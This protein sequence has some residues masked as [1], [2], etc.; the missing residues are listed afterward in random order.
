MFTKI[1]KSN[2]FFAILLLLAS[3]W[4]GR[5]LFGSGFYT[6]SDETHLANLHQMVQ[7]INSGQIPPRW[8]PNFSFNFG[9]P[10]FTFYYL[11]PYYIGSFFNIVFGLSLIWSLK[12]TFLITIIG[13]AL[14]MYFLALK[15]F[16][17]P[18]AFSISLIYLFTPYRAVDLY[19]RGAVGEM[20]G[21]V[22]MPLVLLTTINLLKKPNQTNLF[23][24]SLS[25][26]G[27][28]I[29][30]N[31][32]VL[33]FTP[34]IFLFSLVYLRFYLPKLPKIKSFLVLILSMAISLL[35]SAYY[36]IPAI[37]E[38]QYM[39]SGTPFNPIDHFPFI[40]QLIIPYWGYGAS[41]WGPTDELSFQIG[42]ANLMGIAIML[43]VVFL[44]KFKFKY[45]VLS[46]TLL[47]ILFS[48]LFLMN[49]RSLPIWDLIPIAS[50]IQF[51]WRLLIIT[52]FISPLIIGLISLASNH[53][54]FKII[55]YVLAFV[56]ILQTYPYFRPH[57]IMP[58]DD[59][60]YLTRFFS[61]KNNSED[62]IPLTIWTSIRPDR[63]YATIEPSKD[64]EVSKFKQLS[65][66]NFSFTAKSNQDTTL[67]I[68]KTY[69]P[70]WQATNNNMPIPLSP[71]DNQGRIGLKLSSGNNLITLKFSNTPIRLV[72]NYISLI[73]L[74]VILSYILFRKRNG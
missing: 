11:L 32:T 51:P 69:Y 33:I 30:H 27:L 52:T 47:I 26:F 53:K 45:K 22:L 29:S 55:P 15:F 48:C 38:K 19:V 65:V 70:G 57:T 31:L 7:S 46:V 3:L 74:L 44:F 1:T 5:Y 64:I 10:F 37:L 72:S 43:I 68:N 24:S 35:L 20:F 17:K 63:T 42:I 36:L 62:Y 60:Y 49:I 61:N 50:Y 28:I 41:V 4:Q 25:F 39:Q 56:A 9:S 21:F 66:I 58:V 54:L 6:F 59:S 13:S 2:L 18:T 73:T 67:K 12:L 71:I 23:L 40:K 34:I 14:T 16:N 8:A